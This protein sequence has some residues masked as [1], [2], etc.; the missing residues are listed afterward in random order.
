M[1]ER[2]ENGV[3][4]IERWDRVFRAVSSEPRRQLVVSLLDAPAGESV[5][6]PEGAISATVPDEPRDLRRSLRHRHLPLLADAGFVEWS[7]DPFVASRGPRFDEVA[8]VFERLH[9]GAGELPD[10]LVI[11]CRRLEREREFCCGD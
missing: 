2:Y 3:R 1:R 6:L 5:A 7:A 4:V 11:G 8:V 9:A 10:S